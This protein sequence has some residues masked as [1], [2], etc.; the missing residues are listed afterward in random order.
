MSVILTIF[1]FFENLFETVRGYFPSDWLFF[2]VI[3]LAEMLVLVLIIVLIVSSVKRKRRKKA[4]KAE[5]ARLALL[6]KEEEEAKARIKIYD[7]SPLISYT[8][9]KE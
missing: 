2:M 7:P 8:L 9:I 5:E 4:K 3:G 6:A 1:E